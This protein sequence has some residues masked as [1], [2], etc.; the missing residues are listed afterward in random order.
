M[1]KS[2]IDS[3]IAQNVFYS[4]MTVEF[5]RITRSAVSLSDFTPQVKGL[6]RGMRMQ[7]F[8]GNKTNN[9]LKKRILVHPQNSQQFSLS[10]QNF[11]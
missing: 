10:Y 1:R 6:Q 2:H 4:V 3:K 5:V 7:R 9:S 8:K 11:E